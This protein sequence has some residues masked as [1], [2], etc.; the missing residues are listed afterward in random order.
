MFKRKGFGKRIAALVLAA[1]MI[2]TL[3]PQMDYHASGVPVDGYP[4][5]ND[6]IYK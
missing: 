2:V 1:T 4:I 5:Y 3:V 6:I